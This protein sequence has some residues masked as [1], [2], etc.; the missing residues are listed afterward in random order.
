MLSVIWRGAA[1]TIWRRKC[2][3]AINE[4]G[5]LAYEQEVSACGNV[6]QIT[7]NQIVD[8]PNEVVSLCLR[9]FLCLFRFL[10]SFRQL[11]LTL[12]SN[13]RNYCG[14]CRCWRRC[15][16]S[17]VNCCRIFALAIAL[18]IAL[19]SSRAIITGTSITTWRTNIFLYGRFGVRNFSFQ[20]DT[21]CMIEDQASND[22]FDSYKRASLSWGTVSIEQY[23]NKSNLRR[24][25][26]RVERE[27]Y[28]PVEQ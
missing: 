9:A 12:G 5:R 1:T 15:G 20:P 23:M 10:L 13:R 17:W 16:T 3:S 14:G 6:V 7:C 21:K 4:R 25:R 22:A 27:Q 8:L 24:D 2:D 19:R 28:W 18:V 11:C 26:C